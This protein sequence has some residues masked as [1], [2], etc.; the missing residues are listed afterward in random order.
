MSRRNYKELWEQLKVLV[1]YGG[2]RRYSQ[3]EL[4]KIIT[5]MEVGQ[6]CQDPI[7]EIL[8]VSGEVDKK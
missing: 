3:V 8:K 4:Y 7:S 5:N 1:L 2:K 6:L